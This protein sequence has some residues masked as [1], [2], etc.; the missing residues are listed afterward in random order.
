MCLSQKEVEFVS[1]YHHYVYKTNLT[2]AVVVVGLWA[3]VF[4]SSRQ[5]ASRQIFGRDG[6]K[7][8]F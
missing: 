1:R 4:N 3:V 6:I 8:S 2:G 5:S 7:T